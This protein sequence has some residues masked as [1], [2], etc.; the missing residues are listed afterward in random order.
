MNIITKT[1]ASF[2]L[3]TIMLGTQAVSAAVIQTGDLDFSGRSN[4]DAQFNAMDFSY[5]A[6]NGS[7]N[8]ASAYDGAF[9]TDASG[10]TATKDHWSFEID[11]VYGSGELTNTT[12]SIMNSNSGV[13][14][15]SGIL[16]SFSIAG[17]GVFNFLFDDLSGNKSSLFGDYAGVIFT[18][19]TIPVGFDF[20]TS[21]SST[22]SGNVNTFKT[23][24]DVSEPG[25]L[26]LS[27]LGLGLLF[28]N[29]KKI[30]KA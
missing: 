16:E 12:L 22:L 25:T 10:S 1:M 2:G 26:S 13:S 11:G 24:V 4:P 23:S 9:F 3:A 18:D 29:R 21:Y 7:F 27:L 14:Q 28:A 30:Q 17:D 20:S 19:A 8:I 5:D 6:T 15:L